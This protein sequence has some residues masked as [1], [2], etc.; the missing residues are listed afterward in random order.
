MAPTECR[1]FRV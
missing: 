1:F